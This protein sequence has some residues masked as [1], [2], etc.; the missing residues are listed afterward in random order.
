MRVVLATQFDYVS[1]KEMDPLGQWTGQEF[2]SYNTGG[3]HERERRLISRRTVRSRGAEEAV[4]VCSF[5]SGHLWL[6]VSGKHC[7]VDINA[8]AFAPLAIW[9]LLKWRPES[10]MRFQLWYV[11]L[12][13]RA[14]SRNTTVFFSGAA[15]FYG[16]LSTGP[17]TQFLLGTFNDFYL[18][19]YKHAFWNK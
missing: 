1:G 16:N 9:A 7:P 10:K 13:A 2:T 4:R 8:G 19:R 12:L 17:F 18:F 15:H 6:C 5:Q 11:S 3:E 14:H